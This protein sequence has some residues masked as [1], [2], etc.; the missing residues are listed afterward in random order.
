MQVLECT[1]PNAEAMVKRILE[2]AE[3]LAKSSSHRADPTNPP[4]GREKPETPKQVY[5]EDEEA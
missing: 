5:R 4:N 2:V 3:L 1:P